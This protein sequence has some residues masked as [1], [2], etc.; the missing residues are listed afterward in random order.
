MALREGVAAAQNAC[1]TAILDRPKCSFK[2]RAASGKAGDGACRHARW[3]ARIFS[4]PYPLRPRT[5]T[6]RRPSVAGDLGTEA[7]DEPIFAQRG[8]GASRESVNQPFGA[9]YLDEWLRHVMIA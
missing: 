5:G 1:W 8:M 6:W 7:G 9:T 3:H 2:Q 4:H